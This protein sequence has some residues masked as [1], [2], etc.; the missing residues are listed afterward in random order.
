MKIY[1]TKILT[2]TKDPTTSKTRI[3][4]FQ[5][6]ALAFC[7]APLFFSFKKKR[8]LLAVQAFLRVA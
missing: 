2:M 6:R 3:D 8:H 5:K 1:R 7:R 4:F